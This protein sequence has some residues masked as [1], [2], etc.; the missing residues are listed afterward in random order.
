VEIR[1][2]ASKG[3]DMWSSVVTISGG[4]SG[5]GNGTIQIE[6]DW[7]L[8]AIPVDYGYWNTTAHRHVHDNTTTAK[9]KNYVL[10]QIDDR[11]GT[12]LIEV[13]NT[14]TG[15]AQQ[16]FSYIPGSTPESSPNNFQLIYDDN[17][18]QEVSGF[19][20]KSL[21]AFSFTISWGA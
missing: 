4:G 3:F 8:C 10:D 16:F 6:P 5:F 13:A 7:Q 14:Y 2:L 19:W 1:T 20:I 15:D 21:A 9:F 11:Y 17:G 18:N 12:G